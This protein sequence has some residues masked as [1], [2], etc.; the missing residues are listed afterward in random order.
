MRERGPDMWSA[1]ASGPLAPNTAPAT[2][3]LFGLIPTK[4]ATTPR[5]AVSHQAGA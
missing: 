2:A 4:V 3:V 1:A 5:I